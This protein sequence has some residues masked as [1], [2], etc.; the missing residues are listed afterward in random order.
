MI[1]NRFLT[2]SAY[3]MRNRNAGPATVKSTGD[4]STAE[5]K[6]GSTE[7]SRVVGVFRPEPDIQSLTSQSPRRM[8]QLGVIE[9]SAKP[10]PVPTDSPAFIAADSTI[11]S[12]EA[13]K[14]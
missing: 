3:L 7:A 6:K 12:E 14:E 8:V 9:A 10:R 4:F 11:F 5:V 2:K 1:F 13:K